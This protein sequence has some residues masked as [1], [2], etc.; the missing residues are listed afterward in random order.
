M[1]SFLSK[2]GR[3][4]AQV[5]IGGGRNTKA[6]AAQ[7]ISNLQ[8]V[9]RS[10]DGATPEAIEAGLRLIFNKSQEYVP[11]LSGELKE[12]GYVEVV[13]GFFR[14]KGEVGYAR[15]GRPDYAIIVHELVE[16]QHEA[17][18]SAKYLQKAVEEELDKVAAVMVKVIQ[19]QS[20]IN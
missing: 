17:P 4:K 7:V 1:P 5:K 19:R 16:N 12:S 8:E 9:I 14:H 18:T 3:T 20:G 15:N 13:P 6:Q 10:V 2:A 11:V